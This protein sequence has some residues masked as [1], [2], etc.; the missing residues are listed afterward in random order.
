V[1]YLVIGETHPEIRRQEGERYRDSLV[2]LIRKLHLD[3]HVRFVNH[4]VSQPQLVRYLQATDIYVTPYTNRNQITSGTLAYAL[5]CGK[6]VISTPY[7]YASEALAEGRG[8]L[9]EF[10][11]STSF[12]RCVNM[13]LENPALREL[14]ENNAFAYGRQMSWRTVGARYADLSRSLLGAVAHAPVAPEVRQSAPLVAVYRGPV[15]IPASVSL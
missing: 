10:Q 9:A 12:A 2:D 8:L 6:A 1:L 13:F 5:G 11:D 7:L 3:Q 15:P 14:C 4:Y